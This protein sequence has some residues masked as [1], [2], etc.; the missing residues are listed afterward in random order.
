M[1]YKSK[2]TYSSIAFLILLFVSCTSTKSIETPLPSTINPNSCRVNGTIISIDET[3]SS[4]GP[5]SMHPCV[6]MV[7]INNV[8][9]TGFGFKTPLIKNDTIKIKFEFTLDKTSKELFP[10]LN[11][12]LPGLEVSNNFVADVE[13]IELIQMNNINKEKFYYRVYNYSK[14]Y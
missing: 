2:L 13:R 7:K 5:C 10:T 12:V 6:A 3:K 1:I 8:I 9:G 11:Y 4:S 14:I